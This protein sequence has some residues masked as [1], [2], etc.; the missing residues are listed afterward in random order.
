MS[1]C[2]DCVQPEPLRG[3]IFPRHMSSSRGNSTPPSLPT[4][5][6]SND[7]DG[8]E[9]IVRGRS[10]PRSPPPAEI[11]PAESSAP[12]PAQSLQPEM[13]S[14]SDLQQSPL[15]DEVS[16]GEAEAAGLELQPMLLG[17]GGDS[18]AVTDADAAAPAA[19]PAS[20]PPADVVQPKA[21]AQQ[22][23]DAARLDR[24]QTD[25]RPSSLQAGSGKRDWHAAIRQRLKLRVRIGLSP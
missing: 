5:R 4:G 20:Q 9:L 7:D 25:Q 3:Q 17:T 1:Q 22:A 15:P 21:P 19:Q 24:V 14:V 10:F 18:S 13:G 16:V 2:T 12:A 11:E 8:T 6:L 23:G